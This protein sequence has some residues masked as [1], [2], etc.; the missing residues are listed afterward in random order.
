MS[1]GEDDLDF[2]AAVATVPPSQTLEI[3]AHPGKI[4]PWRI[5]ETHALETLRGFTDAAGHELIRWS[6]L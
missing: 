4:D 5:G 3:G 6:D 2:A 1:V